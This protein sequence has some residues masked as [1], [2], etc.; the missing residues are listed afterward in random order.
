MPLPPDPPFA[1]DERE[2]L[3][4]FLDYYRV[5]AAPQGGRPDAGAARGARCRRPTCRSVGSS[6]TWRWSR[7]TGSCATGS[8]ADPGEP[9]T[10]VDWDGRPRLGL[11]LGRRRRAR[12]TARALH[13][14]DRAQ[15]RGDRGLR[16][17]RRRRPSRADRVI[18]LRWMLVHM[19]EEY[20]RH[21]GHADLAAPVDRRRR[22]AI[23]PSDVSQR[24]G[25][26]PVSLLRVAL[27][28]GRVGGGQL[29]R[30]SARGAPAPRAAAAATIARMMRL[31]SAARRLC[32]NSTGAP[33][34]ALT[35]G[36][37][38]HVQHV[39]QAGAARPDLLGAPQ[40]RPGSPA[41]PR[42]GRAGPHP[43]GP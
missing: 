1:V 9:W 14:G 38:D 11:P 16:R 20:A 24:S 28:A 22:S 31:V 43:T 40:T 32:S 25:A 36:R 10:S 41:H 34:E 17:P 27:V 26:A 2:T 6:S 5:G 19:I 7:T 42:A 18:S 35:C 39:R 12:A 21:C 23:D 4:T 3:V 33:T 15:P 29:L 13:G 8:G 37:V 30:E